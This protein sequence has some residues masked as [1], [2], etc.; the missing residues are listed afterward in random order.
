MLG[1][2]GSRE[3]SKLMGKSK[4][5]GRGKKEITAAVPVLKEVVTLPNE[6]VTCR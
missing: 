6:V 1:D 2:A 5:H 4:C 3:A